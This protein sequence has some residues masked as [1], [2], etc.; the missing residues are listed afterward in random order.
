MYVTTITKAE[1]IADGKFENDEVLLFQTLQLGQS[2]C[3][4]STDKK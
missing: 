4:E 3:I 2:G 1:K